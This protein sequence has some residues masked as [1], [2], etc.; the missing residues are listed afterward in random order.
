M[1]FLSSKP[2][3]GRWLRA[4]ARVTAGL[5]M[6]FVGLVLVS[7]GLGAA[8]MRRDSLDCTTLPPPAGSGVS[9]SAISRV[10][11]EVQLF[12]LGVR[13]SYQGPQGQT[14][15]VSNI[16]LWHT[17]AIAAGLVLMGGGVLFPLM[18]GR[19]WTS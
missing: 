6:L 13:C 15:E 19:D 8:G 17:V 12:P 16:K 3:L 18:H 1:T 11:G 7:G 10:V 4:A 2:P 5:V 14:V 9:P